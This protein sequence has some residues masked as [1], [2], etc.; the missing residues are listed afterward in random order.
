M[1]AQPGA[2]SSNRL[3][4]TL[5]TTGGLRRR[6]LV[7][8]A[9]VAL[10]SLLILALFMGLTPFTSGGY[11]ELDTGADGVL[12]RPRE[13]M[14]MP[15]G[16]AGHRA[17]GQGFA[18][19]LP[20]RLSVSQLTV[21]TGYVATVLLGL[22]LLV[23]PANLLFRRRN[24]V[25]SYL[26]RDVG[27]WTVMFSIVHVILGLQL[28]GSGGLNGFL[29]YFVARDGGVLLNSFGLGNWT[30]LAAVVVAV[31]LLAISTD[32]RMHELKARRWKNLQRLNYALFALVALHAFFYGALLRA[33]SP[34]TL[35]LISTVIAVLS[36]QLAGTWLWRRRL[37]HTAGRRQHARTA[38]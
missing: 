34:F 35:V 38:R 22:T 4:R 25:S 20:D 17:A 23:G 32:R 10:G 21:A 13:P 28:H 30:G 9:P 26:R 33:T 5:G 36:A 6:L 2:R 11:A 14:R 16:D 37:T 27:T 8:H 7:H 3:G 19:D 31:G 15:M 24:P 12:P 29:G 1:I 18:F